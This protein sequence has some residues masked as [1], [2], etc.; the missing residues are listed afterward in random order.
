LKGKKVIIAVTNDLVIDQRVNRTALTLLNMGALPVLV[1]RL[2]PSTRDMEHRSYPIHRI[3]MIFRKGILFYAFF[4]VRLLVFLLFHKA[5]LLVSND[6]DTLPACFLAAGIKSLPLV[7]DSHEYFTEVPELISRRF[8][9]N[10]W[11]RIE[12]RI[13]PGLKYCCTVS[14][15]IA[16]AYFKTY[17]IRMEVIR[18]FPY[19]NRKESRRPDLLSCDPGRI[20]IYQGALNVG[21]GLEDMIKAMQFLEEYTFQIFG[22]GDIAGELVNLSKAAK[23]E[24]Q[25][26]FMGRVPFDQL[27]AYTRQ[28]SIG[29][30]LEED[31]GLSYRYALPNKLFDYIHAG[32]PVLVSPL[33]EMI[34]VLEEY[35]IGRVL[36]DRE[37]EEIAIQVR[38]MMENEGL[39]MKWKQNLRKAATE[40]CWER[41]E[42][43][44]RQLLLRAATEG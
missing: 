5:D 16:D 34:K 14:Q 30:S 27:K 40:L 8:A 31:L 38:E 10:F 43:K 24:D 42:E 11:K 22:D 20:I 12:K 44:L 39:R 13:L 7:Y 41:E 28:A 21:R 32:I 9:R 2:L 25:V 37:P 23:V 17:G 36:S 6:L 26:V 15:S 19:G 4:N 18:N 33:P 29:I 1:G 35:D 3:R